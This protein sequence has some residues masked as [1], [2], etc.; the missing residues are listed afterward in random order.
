MT[1][2]TCPSCDAPAPARAPRCAR[3][4][5][6]FVEDVGPA[7]RRPRPSRRGLAAVAGGSALIAMG[8]AA[9]ALIGGGQDDDAAAGGDSQPAH[10]EVLAEHPLN[11]PAAERLLTA[12]YLAAPDD[13]QTDVRCAGREPRPA[14]SVRRCDILYPGGTIRTVVLITNANGSEVLSEP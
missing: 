2:T 10:L 13:D 11:T 14:H 5:Y 1:D 3:C 6:P 4:G 12:R 8:V 9:V 7:L